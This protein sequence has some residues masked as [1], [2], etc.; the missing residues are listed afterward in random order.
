MIPAGQ[1]WPKK[2]IEGVLEMKGVTV[3]E[4]S[5]KAGLKPYTLRNVFY[6]HWPKGERII[7]EACGV[8]PDVIWPSRFKV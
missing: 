6:R 4:L 7:S 8:S 3:V 2:F 1:D 5:E